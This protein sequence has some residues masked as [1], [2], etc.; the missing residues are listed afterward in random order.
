MKETSDF[1]VN[2]ACLKHVFDIYRFLNCLSMICDKKA[3]GLFN[4]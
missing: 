3:H 2:F 1:Q 4:V